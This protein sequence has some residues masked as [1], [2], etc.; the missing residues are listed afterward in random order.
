MGEFY[1][2]HCPVCDAK[3]ANQ[4]PA[5]EDVFV[6]EPLISGTP[7]GCGL[8]YP[9]VC[10]SIGE[11]IRKGKLGAEAKRTVRWIYRPAIYHQKV[12]FVCADCG[13]WHIDDDI[14]I[15]RR[16]KGVKKHEKGSLDWRRDQQAGPRVE[17]LCYLD[18]ERYNILWEK[19]SPC[20][21]CGGKTEPQRRPENLNC[22]QCGTPLKI[23][24]VGN[25]D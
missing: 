7:L 18:K 11:S 24:C 16:K 23:R 4:E 20:P 15:C 1:N 10:K 22:N 21:Y 2:F 8:S 12:V 5:P 13:K 19:E 17:P 9:Y 6:Y 14:R 3:P 25:W